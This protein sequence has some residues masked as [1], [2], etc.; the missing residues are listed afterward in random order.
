MLNPIIAAK[1]NI[2]F[3]LKSCHLLSCL[4]SKIKPRKALELEK[5][6]HHLRNKNQA[7]IIIKIYIIYNF[8]ILIIS[9]FFVQTT[10]KNHQ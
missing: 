2:T 9:I 7:I 8:H 1:T 3:S 10:T 6:Y 4:T 5:K